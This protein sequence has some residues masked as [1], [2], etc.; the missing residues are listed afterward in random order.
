VLDNLTGLLWE[1]KTDD[2]GSRDKDNKYTWKDALAYCENLLLGNQSDWRMP[3]PK[4][5]ERLVDLSKASPPT[6]D[7]TYFPNTS[8]GLYWTGTTCAGCHRRKA[9]AE[10]FNTGSLYYGNK[11]FEGVYYENY[12]RCVTN[13]KPT[14]IDL[15]SFTASPKINKVVLQWSTESENDNAGFNI[16]RATV[17]DGEYLKINGSL[18]SAQGSPT[19]GAS[20]AFV[21]REVKNRK[22]Y[23]Y[24]LEDI[25]LNGMSTLHGPVTATPWLLFRFFQ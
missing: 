4:E 17:E 13:A 25:D 8:N 21:D 3:T 15:S 2:G 11:Y 16:Y 1:Q 6:I 10:D 9:I 22:T 14:V 24:K 20:Y 5:F 12:V 18:I 23:Y 19:Q 7:T